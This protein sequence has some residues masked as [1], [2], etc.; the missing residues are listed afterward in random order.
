MTDSKRRPQ[1]LILTPTR[2]LAVQ[3]SNDIKKMSRHIQHSIT[4]VYG[5]HS[6]DIEIQALKKGVSIVA[7]TPG[8]V[9]DHIQHGN[10]DTRHIRFLVL[11]EADRMLDMGFLD[12]VMR[13]SEPSLKTE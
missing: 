2:E 10:L 5:Q 1:G 6:M 8:R 3:V 9:Y 7:G 11:D 13:S 12:Q 4:S